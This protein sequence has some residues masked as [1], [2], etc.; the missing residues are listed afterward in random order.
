MLTALT[1]PALSS[2][3]NAKFRSN[4]EFEEFI[5]VLVDGKEIRGENYIAYEGSTAVELKASFL[6]TLSAGE[7]SLSI[8]SQNGTA[9]TTFTIVR[10]SE[11][12]GTGDSVDISLLLSLVLIS[13]G[14]VSVFAVLKKKEEN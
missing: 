8:V 4:A 2:G 10:N 5:K 7:H 6:K 12:P 11:T 9:T 1:V 3:V 14:M 13:G